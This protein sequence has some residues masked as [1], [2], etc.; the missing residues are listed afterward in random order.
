MINNKKY[1]NNRLI[2]LSIFKKK[3][4][5][6]IKNKTFRFQKRKKNKLGEKL[7]ISLATLFFQQ[8][9]GSLIKKKFKK[10][11]LKKKIS[12]K[13]LY[14]LEYRLDM[15]VYRCL[16]AVTIFQSQ[17]LI[18]NGAISIN[19]KIIKYNKYQTYFQ[20]LIEVNITK[21][22]FIYNIIL[23]SFNYYKLILPTYIELNLLTLQGII[24]YNFTIRQIP[25]VKYIPYKL[26]I[27]LL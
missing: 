5:V 11:I 8:Y 19:N 27:S 25:I 17:N 24:I 16:F 4:I 6:K 23:F 15:V 10:L 9:Y 2:N 13:I 22:S 21:K 3:K 7:T 14:S 26:I 18:K 1:F 12:I 20:D